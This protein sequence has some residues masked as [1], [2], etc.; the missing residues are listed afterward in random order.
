M[1]L[2]TNSFAYTTYIQY[3]ELETV[4]LKDLLDTPESFL[5]K[6]RICHKLSSLL[7]KIKMVSIRHTILSQTKQFLRETQRIFQF[8]LGAALVLLRLRLHCLCVIG[9]Q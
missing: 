1:G 8:T 9:I 7:K 3:E 4:K 5:H 2:N 6:G